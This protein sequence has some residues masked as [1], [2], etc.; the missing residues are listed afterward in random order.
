[1]YLQ[2]AADAAKYGRIS[3]DPY[4]D[5]TVP[6]L[7]DPSLA[8]EGGHVMSVYAQYSPY[9]LR[10]GDWTV[11][12]DTLAARV[13][14]TLARH[15]PGLPDRIR[16]V[17]VV[18]P[19]DLEVTY[20]MTGG[21]PFHGEPALDQ[22]FVSRPVYGWAQYRTPVEGL[23]LCGAGAHPGG[24]LTGGP[25]ANAAREILRDLGVPLGAR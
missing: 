21:H 14:D 25:G 1:M 7:A 20:G 10:D 12:R 2:R 3:D 6:S 18:T 4:L 9:N 19:K 22:L 13:I 5:L 23:Y 15:A 16:H 11:A 17:Q 8:P 24:G